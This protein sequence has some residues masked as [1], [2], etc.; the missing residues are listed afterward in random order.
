M[1]Q[2]GRWAPASTNF[3][4]QLFLGTDR[5]AASFFDFIIVLRPN[6]QHKQNN[7]NLFSTFDWEYSIRGP[8]SSLVPFH[9]P[10]TPYYL[11]MEIIFIFSLNWTIPMTLFVC[12]FV[13]HKFISALWHNFQKMCSGKIPTLT[14]WKSERVTYLPTDWLTGAHARY[15]AASKN[16]K[17]KWK[18]YGCICRG[19]YWVPLWIDPRVHPS[20]RWQTNRCGGEGDGI[21]TPFQQWTIIDRQRQIHQSS[22]GVL[23]FPIVFSWYLMIS[24]SHKGLAAFT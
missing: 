22:K 9:C 10:H 8:W 15:T 24:P 17:E 21:L 5:A 23:G 20:V 19:S 7:R 2:T 14:E 13:T 6:L 4:I 11:V 1:S 3:N 16:M 18:I 12:Q